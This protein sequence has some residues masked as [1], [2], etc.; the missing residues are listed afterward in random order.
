MFPPIGYQFSD[1]YF[2]YIRFYTKDAVK[3]KAFSKN[4]W[5][6]HPIF[7]IQ[8]MTFYTSWQNQETKSSE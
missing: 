6:R 3:N 4:S 8:E 5:K 7:F 1:M 2:R